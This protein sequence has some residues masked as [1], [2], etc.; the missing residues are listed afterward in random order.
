MSMLTWLSGRLG[1]T[2]NPK[3][4][5]RVRVR[6]HGIDDWG[7]KADHVE[8]WDPYTDSWQRKADIEGSQTGGHY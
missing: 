3:T 4:G 5:Q 1:L 8:E 6:S 2:I 7:N